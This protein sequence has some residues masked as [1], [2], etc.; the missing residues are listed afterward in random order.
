MGPCGSVAG[1]PVADAAAL[2]REALVWD[3]LFPATEAC[4]TVKDHQQMLD[5]MRQSGLDAVSLTMAYDPEDADTA[6]RRIGV[7]RQ[8]IRQAPE[9]FRLVR[10]AEDISAAKAADQLAIGLHFQGSAPFAA[11]PETVRLFHELGIRQAILVY[12]REST[13]GG[14]CHDPE[15]Q[16]LTTRGRHLLREMHKVG[17]FVDCSHTGHRTA[18]DAIEMGSGPV[19]FSHA[20]AAALHPHPRNI[21]DD[22]AVA[23][24]QSGGLVG[25]C[26]VSV[27]FGRADRLD[28][29]LFA[30]VD[31]WVSLLGPENVG[32]G[33]DTVSSFA[34]VEAAVAKEPDKWPADAGYHVTDMACCSPGA[35]EALTHRMLAAGYPE[36]TCRGILGE[37][38]LRAA[39]QVWGGTPGE[40]TK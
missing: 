19:F 26:G 34:A 2:V 37:N 12:N 5:D 35:Y 11:H 22:L 33:L 31:H 17:M 7:W 14:G 28:D 30:H 18:R 13:L 3:Q 38:W 1:A 25:V 15:D 40:E 9:R 23:A 8:I 39:R 32:L 27:F 4:G 36:P 10:S 21:L 16:G 20:N 6:L 24:V 29:D